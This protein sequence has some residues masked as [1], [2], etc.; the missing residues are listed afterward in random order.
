MGWASA[1]VGN[2]VTEFFPDVAR[3]INLKVVFLQRIVNRVAIEN[4]G[5]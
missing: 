1:P 5:P 2:Y 3:R 4:G